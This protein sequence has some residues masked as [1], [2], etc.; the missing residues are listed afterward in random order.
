[1]SSVEYGELKAHP[2]CTLSRRILV[3]RARNLADALLEVRE[4]VAS[5]SEEMMIIDET[6]SKVGIKP[7]KSEG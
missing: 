3:R 2:H 5:G 1:M 4:L 7:Y 6:L